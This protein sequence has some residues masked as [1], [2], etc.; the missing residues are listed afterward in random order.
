M[1]QQ[2]NPHA[3]PVPL[4]AARPAS[5]SLASHQARRIKTVV[6][7]LALASWMLPLAFVL[8]LPPLT[9]P[10]AL[11]SLAV[12]GF[13]FL[14]SLLLAAALYC[15]WC[16]ERI[17]FVAS[18]FNSPSCRQIGRQFVPYDVVVNSRFTCPHCRSRFALGRS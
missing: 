18:M 3:A 6:I 10:V 13:C 2:S 15:P 11:A 12:C 17:F 16:C 5:S 4:D 8:L 1:S 14:V 7:A 9:R